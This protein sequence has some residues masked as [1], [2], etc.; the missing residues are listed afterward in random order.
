VASAGSDQTPSVRTASTS[1]SFDASTSTL[2]TG[3]ISTAGNITASGNITGGGVRSTSSTSPPVS[4]SVGDIWYYTTTDTIYR[5]S[6]NNSSYYWQ[7][8]SGGSIGF[9]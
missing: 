6:Y 9:S 2:S 3:I 5:Y 8:I 1:L 4:P 7:D